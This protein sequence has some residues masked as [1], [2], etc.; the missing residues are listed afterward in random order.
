MSILTGR[1]EPPTDTL[2]GGCY[3]SSGS[4]GRT[5]KH[6]YATQQP[7]FASRRTPKL[8]PFDEINRVVRMTWTHL[9]L[10]PTA[11]NNHYSI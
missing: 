7:A 4:R 3:S 8:F 10:Q 2:W 5:L 6:N 1:L 11:E 9:D